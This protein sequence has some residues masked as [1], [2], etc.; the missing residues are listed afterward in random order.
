MADDF[1]VTPM[2]IMLTVSNH[3][4]SIAFYTGALG[5]T[6]RFERE[7]AVDF[8]PTMQL[9]DVRFRESFLALGPMVLALLSYESPQTLPMPEHRYNQV[10]IKKISF[11]VSDLDLAARRIACSGGTV[12]E[13]T[14]SELPEATLL[15]VTDPDGNCLT[16]VQRSN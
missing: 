3:D 4:R 2:H 1:T 8:E 10:G 5:F 14:R 15:D 16:L 9:H 11:G 13:H 7:A 6:L 12:L